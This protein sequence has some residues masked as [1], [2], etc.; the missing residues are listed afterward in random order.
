MTKHNEFLAAAQQLAAESP[1]LHAEYSR[2][3][4][5]GEW[6]KAGEPV[7]A[8]MKKL[9]ALNKKALRAAKVFA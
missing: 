7:T 8:Y 4:Q 9:N 3:R 5:A 6:F 1:E 2:R